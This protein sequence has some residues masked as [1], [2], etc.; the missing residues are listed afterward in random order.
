MTVK[1]RLGRVI[2]TTPALA[3]M[4]LM[5]DPPD[6]EPRVPGMSPHR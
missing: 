6:P 1:D 4:S 2:A 3:K 5:F